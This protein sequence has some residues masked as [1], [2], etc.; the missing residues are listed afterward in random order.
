MQ[1][2]KVLN[3]S[4]QELDDVKAALDVLEFSFLD[5]D[6]DLND[7]QFKSLWIQLTSYNNLLTHSDH[8]LQGQEDF[9]A[10]VDDYAFRHW[11]QPLSI[12]NAYMPKLCPAYQKLKSV[13]KK[14]TDFQLEKSKRLIDIVQY[15]YDI[16]R[17]DPEY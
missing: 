15:G 5:T 9:K 12:M 4:R 13:A 16:T 8:A 1:R 7:L 10:I 17:Y 11:H 14:Y 2:M 6:Y 3:T